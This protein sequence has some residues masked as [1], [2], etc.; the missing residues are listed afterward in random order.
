ML[1]TKET[2]YKVKYYFAISLS[3]NTFTNHSKCSIFYKLF[4]LA[5]KVSIFANASASF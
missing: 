4:K 3:L 2:N 5:C 1:K